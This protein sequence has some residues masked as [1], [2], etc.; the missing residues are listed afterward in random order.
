MR[1]RFFGLFAIIALIFGLALTSVSMTSPAGLPYVSVD[2]QTTTKEVGMSFNINIT[3]TGIIIPDDLYSWEARLTFDPEILNCTSAE[4]GP[5]L[6]QIGPTWW[7]LTVQNEQGWVDLRAAFRVRVPQGATGNGT[8]ATVTFQALAVGSTPLNFSE[9]ELST[10]NK[11]SGVSQPINQAD[12]VPG[13]FTN[14]ARAD[15]AITNVVP[16]HTEVTVGENVAITV[17]V[18]NEGNFDETFNVAVYYDGTLI[19]NKTAI[20][21]DSGNSTILIFTW[22]TT[23]VVKGTY[24]IKAEANVVPDEIDTADNTFEDGT[25]KVRGAA[26][27]DI[28]LYAAIGIVIIIAAAIAIYFVRFRKPKQTLQPRDTSISAACM[29]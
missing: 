1:K 3:V 27:P 16:S 24:T 26:A 2:P 11:T 6:K 28:L 29:T 15:V 9:T 18:E 8:L 7:W 12:P 25:V 13:F 21:L 10:V 20:F 14:L 23:D 4:E 19:E 22:D 17:T 5:F